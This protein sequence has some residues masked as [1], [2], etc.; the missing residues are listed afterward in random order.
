MISTFERLRAIL[1]KDYQLAPDTV[2]MQAKLESLGIDS[3][4]VAELLFSIE[5]EYRVTLPP[6]PVDLNTVGE[7]VHYIDALVAGRKPMELKPVQPH[8]AT[9]L[10]VH[11]S[12]PSH[13]SSAVSNMHAQASAIG[14]AQGE[15]STALP[16]PHMQ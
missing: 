16:R 7:V 1:V 15:V 14:S 10:K 12:V 6:E 13:V 9:H 4:G 11:S 3:L 2:T 5:D 8:H